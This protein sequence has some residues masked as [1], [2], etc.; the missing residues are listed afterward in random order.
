MVMALGLVWLGRGGPIRQDL[1]DGQWIEIRHV[2]S[3][4]NGTHTIP[5]GA[6]W[7]RDLL[8]FPLPGRIK[9][10][11]E[12]GTG[13]A[14]IGGE[15]LSLGIWW[16]AGSTGTNASGF[17]SGQ[18]P[19]E[20][21]NAVWRVIGDNGWIYPAELRGTTAGLDN[22]PIHR[23]LLG[24]FPR[25]Q[26]RM[27]VEMCN[28][29]NGQVIASFV[30]DNPYPVATATWPPEAFPASY[31][32]GSLTVQLYGID[33][34]T[35]DPTKPSPTFGLTRRFSPRFSLTSDG[36][37]TA[38]WEAT[39]AEL[40]DA[41][42]NWGPYLDPS[43]AG[44]KVRITVRPKALTRGPADAVAAWPGARLRV[45]EPGTWMPLSQTLTLDGRAYP[46]L[47]LGGPGRHIF[48]ND[49][50]SISATMPGVGFQ[51]SNTRIGTQSSTTIG[52]PQ[53]ILCGL[54]WPEPPAGSRLLVRLRDANGKE[55]AVNE[56]HQTGN[57]RFFPL[58]EDLTGEFTFELVLQK[59]E[60][61]QFLVAPPAVGTR[62]GRVAP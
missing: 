43:E 42:G 20:F 30:I 61:V 9:G 49:L 41:S 62:P 29:T 59:S 21:Q 44:W 54:G 46:V 38:G 11:V 15:P 12:T 18:V 32:I 48:T 55:T 25:R 47:G 50:H 5:F 34:A 56:F 10:W 33:S 19:A 17:Q 2:T 58:P 52:R 13:S 23:L 40:F 53:A 1:P 26:A 6:R 4:T 39:S 36:A 22:V 57:I 3:T 51:S 8:K 16:T 37:A 60:T 35:V 27:R 28:R 31:R 45:P 14:G 24:A 7:R